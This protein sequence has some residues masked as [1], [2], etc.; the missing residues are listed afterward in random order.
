MMGTSGLT[1]LWHRIP[2]VSKRVSAGWMLF[3]VVGA[4][5]F[6]YWPS[7]AWLGGE[8]TSTRG[9]FSHG[10]LIAGIC[11]F[12]LFRSVRA[13]DPSRAKPCWQAIPVLLALSFFW[14]LGYVS[15]V[16]AV[17]TMLLPVIILTAVLAAFGRAAMLGVAF[18]IL[19]LYF[20][21]PAW[22][23]LRF[24]FQ[25]ITTGIV[26]L[27][28]RLVDIPVY[29]E[30]NFVNIPAGTFEISGGCSG[31]GFILVGTSLA[32][33]Y[34]HLFYSSIRN[35][36]LLAG[37]AFLLA[38]VVNWARV[39][40]IVLIGNATDMKHPLVADHSNFG[41]LLFAVAMIP[42]FYAAYRIQP[43]ALVMPSAGK[44]SA[45][46]PG[47]NAAV[48]V[49]TALVILSLAVAP[50]WG[51]MLRVRYAELAPIQLQLPE[52]PGYWSGPTPGLEEWSPRFIGAS[53]EVF[54]EY[55][56]DS[57]SVWL[58]ANAYQTESQDRELIHFENSAVGDLKTDKKRIRHFDSL[59]N[60]PGNV[61][62]VEADGASH[63]W[64]I[65]YWYEVGGRSV[66]REA[67]AKA[68][69]ALAF[70]SGNP[71]SGIVAMAARCQ[72]SCAAATSRMQAFTEEADGELRLRKM[73]VSGA[74]R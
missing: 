38:V 13:S 56:S 6:L 5:L 49:A 2:D 41:W 73:I 22:E 68:M 42:M 29:V 36:L 57:G 55:R 20:A 45:S 19:Y 3:S 51:R 40:S 23:H 25:N 46:A 4:V 30:G 7:F 24:I 26:D 10:Y 64:L 54:G 9:L 66:T 27:L 71:S 48:G 17:Q 16:V 44:R 15:D 53:P 60:F 18:A 34:G 61:V 12:L 69:Q 47:G 52:A 39:F 62:E 70:I 43:D 31:L 63:R 50:V 8:W 33:L 32:A 58:Y 21:I 1:L 65:W 14:L 67:K 72:S 11:I 59:S 35:K 28:V 37:I 74:T